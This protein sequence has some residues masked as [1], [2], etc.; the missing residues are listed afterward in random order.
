MANYYTEFSCTLEL[1]IE[2]HERALVIYNKSQ[3]REGEPFE[4]GFSVKAETEGTPY[5][6]FYADESGIPDLLIEYI[7]QL[8]KEFK[9]I[10]RWGFAWSNTCSKPRLD[11]FGGGACV[12]NLKTQRIIKHIDCAG[13]LMNHLEA[14][15]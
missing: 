11:G 9:L 2:H 7:S 13:W 12:M 10:G 3:D 5:L 4:Y 6:W 8:A 1:P 15:R 14:E